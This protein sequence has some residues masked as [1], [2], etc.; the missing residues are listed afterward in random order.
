MS[1]V[2]CFFCAVVLSEYFL[3]MQLFVLAWL[4]LQEGE[5]INTPSVL[6]LPP[7]SPAHEGLRYNPVLKFCG[8]KS[9]L[10]S[11]GCGCL[12]L[13]AIDHQEQ[14]QT[15]TIAGSFSFEQP[16]LLLDS[17]ENGGTW[18]CVVATFDTSLA[19]S[20]SKGGERPFKL[21]YLCL[22]V[23]GDGQAEC[24]S[25]TC[26]TGTSLPLYSSLSR[27]EGDL[28]MLSEGKFQ[29][30]GT[31]Q[32]SQPSSPAIA[33]TSLAKK[34][35]HDW[36]QTSEFVTVVFDVEADV[37]ARDVVFSLTSDEVSLGLTDGVSLLR[38]RL[39][40]RVDVEGSAWTIVN[41]RLVTWSVQFILH[42]IVCP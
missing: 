37:R 22:A 39:A 19:A 7:S 23:K 18:S 17:V 31:D 3:P 34:K 41:H 24:R 27:S 29:L 14:R 26:L 30:V 20:D 36:Q 8:E 12:H 32:T 25:N 5:T 38:G 13:V 21:H 1:D 33:S 28:C 35:C 40:S 16:C 15:W 4:C 42:V 2:L 6:D 9:A 11:D 10:V